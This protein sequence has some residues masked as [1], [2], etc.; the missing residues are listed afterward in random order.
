MKVTGYG[1]PTQV[2][3]PVHVYL[4]LTTEASF[5]PTNYKGAQCPI[6]PFTPRQLRDEFPFHQRVMSNLCLIWQWGISPYSW[7]WWSSVVQGA[8]AWKPGIPC[9]YQIPKPANPQPNQVEMPLE[10]EQMDIEIPQNLLNLIN[11]PEEMLSDLI[12]GHTVFWTTSGNMTFKS[13]HWRWI[14]IWNLNSGQ[15]RSFTESNGQY[16]YSSSL[17]LPNYYFYFKTNNNNNN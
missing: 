17:F 4:V 5:N 16:V 15:W 2:M 7:P 6:S 14:A 12:L 3:R 8:C 11:V 9:I 1:L 10:P 13:H